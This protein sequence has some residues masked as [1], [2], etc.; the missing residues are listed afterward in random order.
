MRH[1]NLTD[2]L[3]AQVPHGGGMVL[4]TPIGSGSGNNHMPHAIIGSHI[5]C[6]A[7]D[8]GTQPTVNTSHVVHHES[9]RLVTAHITP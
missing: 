3:D 9:P 2:M 5:P 8:Q 1:R 4:F 6:I 7:P